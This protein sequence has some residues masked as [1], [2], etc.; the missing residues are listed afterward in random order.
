MLGQL[1][2]PSDTVRYVP[3]LADDDG[4]PLN[5]TDTYEVTVPAGIVRDGGYFSV[6][7]YGAD[8]KQM[9]RANVEHVSYTTDLEADGTAVITLSPT[10]GGRNGIPTGKPFY[11]ILWAYEPMHGADLRPSVRKR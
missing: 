10:G 11:G 1:G 8:N 3:I 6:T 4:A 2:T 7:V 5:G 9:V